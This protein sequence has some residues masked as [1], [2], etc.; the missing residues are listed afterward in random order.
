QHL[1]LLHPGDA[2]VERDP[3]A[4]D[5]GRARA[6]VGLQHVAVDGE[7]A[8]AER[9]EVNHRTQAA[10]DQALDLDGAAALLAGGGFAPRA[11]ERGARSMPYSAVIHPR[12]WPLSHGGRRSSTVAVTS[13]WVSPN[14]T[15]Q[16]PS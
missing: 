3:G 14:F 1:A 2:V 16:E 9:N 7:L 10:S 11:L 4:G 5:R 15:R 12:P 6:A 8:L 13:T